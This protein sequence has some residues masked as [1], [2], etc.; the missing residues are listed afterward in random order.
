MANDT[1]NSGSGAGDG[2]EARARE[3]L[4]MARAKW[5]LQTMQHRTRRNA[6]TGEDTKLP[7]RIRRF[8]NGTPVGMKDAVLAVLADSAPYA[9]PVYDCEKTEGLSYR[10]T[11][12]FIRKDGP[13]HTTGGKDPTYTIIQDLLLVDARGD[14]LGTRSESSCSRLSETEYVWDAA[15]VADADVGGQGVSYEVV[16]VSRDRETDLFSYQLRRVV[17]L[18][19]HSPA[20]VVECDSRHTA[21]EETWDNL[22][23][24]PGAFRKDGESSHGAGAAVA[25]PEPCSS[26]DG[27][28]VA[29][30]TRQNADCTYRVVVRTSVAHADGRGRGSSETAFERNECQCSP[31]Y[32]KDLRERKT[33]RHSPSGYRRAVFQHTAV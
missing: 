27:T 19:Q 29:V 8:L 10:P 14:S 5:R 3:W 17:A 24:G 11:N 33:S 32:G 18:T 15:E 28:T 1:E 16:N 31:P 20:Q 30:D 7:T 12:T 13:E 4:D 25:I 9:S 23:G 26:P 22:Y 21:T 6:R 2:L